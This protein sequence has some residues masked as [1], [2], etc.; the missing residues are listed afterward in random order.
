MNLTLS[1]HYLKGVGPKEKKKIRVRRLV[2]NRMCAIEALNKIK[3]GEELGC[4]KWYESLIAGRKYVSEDAGP[5]EEWMVVCNIAQRQKDKGPYMEDL[6]S[7]V[8]FFRGYAQHRRK[9]EAG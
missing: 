8:F 5:Q 3:S 7:I 2:K 4:Y 6:N 1:R 9:I